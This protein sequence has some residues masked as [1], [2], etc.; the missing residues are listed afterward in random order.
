MISQIK[1]NFG[2][3]GFFLLEKFY[4]KKKILVIKKKFLE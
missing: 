1:T 4:S 3:N 2:E